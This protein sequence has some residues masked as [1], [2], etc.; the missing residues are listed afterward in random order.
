MS[1]SKEEIEWFW[2]PIFET[3]KNH[4]KNWTCIKDKKKA[5]DD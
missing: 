4:N 3:E 1:P 5:V 2:G